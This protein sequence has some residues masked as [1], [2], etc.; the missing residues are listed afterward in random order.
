MSLNQQPHQ[1]QLV[2]PSSNGHKVESEREGSARKD[3]YHASVNAPVNKGRGIVN[4]QE[5][6]GW[7][8]G[9]NGKQKA[10]MK[11]ESPTIAK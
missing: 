2:Q 1:R 6:Q 3:G 8:T 7:T 10:G 5:V 9:A 11:R 4:L